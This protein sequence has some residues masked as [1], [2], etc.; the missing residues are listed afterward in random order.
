M[1]FSALSNEIIALLKEHG[2]MRS[3][4]IAK[5]SNATLGAIRIC[6]HRLRQHNKVMAEQRGLYDLW[7][8]PFF[9]TASSERDR[10]GVDIDAVHRR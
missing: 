1:R 8:N 10:P 7:R 5:H 2:P 9:I 6:V 4:E 3:K